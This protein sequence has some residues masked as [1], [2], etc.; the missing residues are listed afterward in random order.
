M[1]HPLI[2]IFLS[3]LFVNFISLVGGLFLL[4]KK[5]TSLL[6]SKIFVGF[7][8]GVLLGTAILDILPESL[9]ETPAR[10]ASIALLFGIL[11]FFLLERFVV[12][13]HHHDDTHQAKPTAL[14]ILVGDGIHNFIDGFAIAASY[15]T[16]VHLGIVTTM[17]IAAHEIPQELAD[18]GI[19]ISGGLSKKRALLWNFISGLTALAGGLVAF[20]A[21]QYIEGVI[22]LLLAFT[23]GMFLYIACSDLIP[24]LHQEFKKTKVWIQTL[25][26]LLGILLSYIMVTFLE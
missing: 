13:F 2:Y 5:Q 10:L 20:Y 16:N 4:G 18:L 17:A 6:S 9:E 23:A 26:F 12:W 25:P 21:I 19:L 3:T 22:P 1:L 24:D 15:L 7:A 14:L 8:A 11:T